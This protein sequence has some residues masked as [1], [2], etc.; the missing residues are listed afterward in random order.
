MKKYSLTDNLKRSMKESLESFKKQF[1]LDKPTLDDFKRISKI[2]GANVSLGFD[3]D[4]PRIADEE[5]NREKLNQDFE[6]L[7]AN[8]N[9]KDKT[10]PG[11]T[12]KDTQVDVQPTQTDY[13]ATTL[14]DKTQVDAFSST[15][16]VGRLANGLADKLAKKINAAEPMDQKDLSA[17]IEAEIKSYL[18]NR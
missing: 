7:K 17:A 6:E 14:A 12:K 11:R 9:E 1:K 16:V 2:P 3:P 18:S 5:A 13:D 10:M 15:D 8:Q 4:D